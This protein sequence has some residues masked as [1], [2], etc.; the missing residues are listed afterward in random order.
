MHLGKQNIHPP[1][2]YKCSV[3][4]LSTAPYFYSIWRKTDY[5][6]ARGGW[7]LGEV[8]GGIL[9]SDKNMTKR[10]IR[11][12][13]SQNILDMGKFSQV[14]RDDKGIAISELIFQKVATEY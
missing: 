11:F 9:S 13:S 5:F 6:F 7:D 10:G 2:M 3:P 14:K 12:I 1:L 8:S 4:S